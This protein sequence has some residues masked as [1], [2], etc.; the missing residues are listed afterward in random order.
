MGHGWVRI[1]EQDLVEK[2][3]DVADHVPRHQPRQILQ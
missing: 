3:L 2:L 1:R